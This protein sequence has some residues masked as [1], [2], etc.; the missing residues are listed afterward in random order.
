M[1]LYD[2]PIAHRGLHDQTATENSMQAF[3]NA[4][5]KH[6]NIELD[7]HIL[8]DGKIVVFHDFTLKRV[9]GIDV[10]ISNLTSKDLED[11]KYFLPNGEKIPLFEE[12]LNLVDGQVHILCEIKSLSK[13]KFTF[14]KLLYNQIKE[15]RSWITVQSFNPYAMIW[16]RRHASDLQRGQLASYPTKKIFKPFFF[17]LGPIAMLRF[18]H[19]KFLSYNVGDLPAKRITNYCNRYSLDLVV[20]TI[21]TEEQFLIARSMNAKN[22]IFEGLSDALVESFSDRYLKFN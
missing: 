14:E 13:F 11:P 5:A 21:T 19:A 3:K 4:I 22:I 17:L 9:V 18:S 7:V 12:V 10:K 8:K 15:K 6:Y 1:L 16:F 2:R 20:W